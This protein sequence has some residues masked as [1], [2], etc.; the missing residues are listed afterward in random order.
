MSPPRTRFS[1]TR[2]ATF[3]A[4]NHKLGIAIALEAFACAAVAAGD[5]E[6]GLTLAGAAATV[7]RGVGA[8]AAAA[9]DQGTRLEP[10]VADLWALDDPGAVA[11]RQAGS[12]MSLEQAVAYARRSA[13][14]AIDG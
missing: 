8:G 12:M 11:R 9:H 3:A 13:L 2:L 14:R 7:R 5:L 1:R 6:R 4:V 10:R